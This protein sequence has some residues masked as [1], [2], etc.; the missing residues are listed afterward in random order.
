EA[1]ELGT[2]SG[3]DSVVA[4][5]DLEPRL[6]AAVAQLGD[7]GDQRVMALGGDQ[8]ANAQHDRGVTGRR[9]RK[10]QLDARVDD[11]DPVVATLRKGRGDRTGD[12]D[13]P[14]APRTEEPRR[15]AVEVV[16]VL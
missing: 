14:V 3:C 1:F 11:R 6:H 2:V 13:D 5:G 7:G 12:A 9:G 15:G 10:R 4:A 16:A 8:R